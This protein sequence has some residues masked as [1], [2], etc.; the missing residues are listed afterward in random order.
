M[1]IAKANSLG[2]ILFILSNKRG[3]KTPKNI[4]IK[5]RGYSSIP[6]QVFFLFVQISLESVIY[7]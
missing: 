7:N 3:K 4:N 2:L 5:K 6:S 1:I